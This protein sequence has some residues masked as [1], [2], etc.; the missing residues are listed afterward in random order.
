MPHAT[1]NGAG[2]EE[3]TTGSQHMGSHTLGN[4]Q[5][6]GTVEKMTINSFTRDTTH[7]IDRRNSLTVGAAALLAGALHQVRSAHAGN[8]GNKSG[9]RCK[10]QREQCIAF[11]EE[12]CVQAV[13]RAG[14]E[15]LD[16]VTQNVPCCEQLG[17]CHAGAA[18]DCLFLKAVK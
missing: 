3:R 14:A 12:R 15:R 7:A 1:A 13:A 9:K 11:L 17:K 18:L 2:V 16:C 4:E 8:G 6:E 10:R 5:V